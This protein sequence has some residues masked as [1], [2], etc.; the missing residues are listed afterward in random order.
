MA[1]RVFKRKIY[2]KILSWKN[3]NDGRSALLIEGARRV[4]KST[5]VEDFARREYKSYILID[6]NKASYEVKELFDDLMDIDFIFLRLQTIYKKKLEVRKSVIIF[7]EV[8]KCP[9][10]RQAI[11]Y[12]VEDGRYDYIETG[13]LISIKKNT[14]SITIPSEEDKLQM[15]PM[16]YEEFR[17]ALGDEVTIPM[18]RTFWEKRKPLQSAH[19]EAARNMRLYMLVGGMPQAVNAYLDTNN[20]GKVDAIKR[21][22]IQLYADDFLKIDPSGKATQMFMSIP[23]ALSNNKNRYTPTSYIGFVDEDKRVELLKALEDSKC[24]NMAYHANDPNVGLPIA[25]NFDRFKMYVGDTGLMVTMAFW[26]KDYTENVIYEKL[27]S[28]KLDANLGYIYENIIA[29]MLTA[30]G[31]KLFYHTWNKRKEDGTI[32]AKHAYEI[33]FLISRGHKI[34][35]IEVKSSG[36]KRHTSLDDFCVKYSSRILHQ[37]LL[38]TK[39]MAKEEQIL[40]VPVYMTPFL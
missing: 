33:D 16:D 23:S 12:L 14:E 32:D 20:F 35:P 34:C 28:D 6:F 18:L 13:S 15:H 2:D 8:Q 40:Y 5:I 30:S 36:Y 31:N 21:K 25:A 1:E 26:D 39:D 10:A 4:G 27:L 7:D 9:N 17:W 37:Y 22:I 3:E 24:V 19:R 11:K 29:Q 38:Y